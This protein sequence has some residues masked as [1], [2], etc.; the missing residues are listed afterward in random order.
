MKRIIL[1]VLCAAVLLVAACEK[2]GPMERA[3]EKLDEAGR[4]LK[5][6]GEKTPADKV[7]DAATDVKKDVEKATD[8]LKK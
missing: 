7:N 1:T 6:G 8:D 2:K 5:N 4:T 3:G